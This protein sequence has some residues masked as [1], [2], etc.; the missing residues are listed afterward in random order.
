MEKVQAGLMIQQLV[1][2][3]GIIPWLVAVISD[4]IY[5]ELYCLKKGLTNIQNMSDNRRLKMFYERYKISS[6]S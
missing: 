6:Q 2:F 5:Q 1:I 3:Q 4:C